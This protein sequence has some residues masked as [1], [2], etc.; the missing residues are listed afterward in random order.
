MMKI[1]QRIRAFSLLKGRRHFSPKEEV[2]MKRYV[3]SIIAVLAACLWVRS[4]WAIGTPVNTVIA[5]QATADYVINSNPL[6]SSSLTVYTTVAEVIDVT[7]VWQ[8]APAL[9]VFPGDPDQALTF[10]VTNT[11]NGAEVFDL[12]A[13]STLG[14]D[15]FD[16]LLQ[17]PALYA[18][19]NTNGVYD[20]GTD[21]AIAGS[22]VSLVRDTGALVF[23]VNNIPAGITTNGYLGDSQLT[24][25][26]QTGTGVGTSVPNGGDGGTVD[27]VIGSTG[28][29]VTVNG[30]YQV[31]V[32]N[33]SLV[34][35]SS[36]LNSY[37]G[38]EP[39]P[40]ATITYDVIV[41][42]SGASQASSFVLTDPIPA[43]TT[44]S[45]GTLSVNPGPAVSST[46]GGAPL[47]VTV[48]FGTLDSTNT[49]QTVTFDVTID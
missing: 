14:G 26:S 12:T 48:D 7:V 42:V 8:D 44:Y 15:D 39:I 6:S 1:A 13:N 17:S 9:N 37:G 24:V 4:A 23:V 31:F 46:V 34:K 28:G 29:T 30:T 47:S 43:N 2:I 25:T 45:P 3:V 20:V 49:P 19:T 27:A 41:T 10:L 35:S 11:G 38:T 40:G 32:T 16:P 18:D 21:L 33:V 5:N 22:T 36:V